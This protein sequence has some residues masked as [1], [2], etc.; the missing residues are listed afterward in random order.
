MDD[1][2]KLLARLPVPA[3]VKPMAPEEFQRMTQQISQEQANDIAIE[4]E[5]RYAAKLAGSSGLN[6]KFLSCNFEN[7]YCNERGQHIALAAAKQFVERFSEHMSTGSGFL[8]MGAPGTGKNHL[9]SA[10]ANALMA[11][12]RSVMVLS[13]MDILGRVRESYSTNESERQLIKAFCKPE[14]LIIDELGLQRGTLDEKLWLHRIINE[15]LYAMRPTGFLT[16]LNMDGL[17]ELL[18]KR[19]YDRMCEGVAMRVK[20]DWQSYRGG[21]HAA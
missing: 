11:K 20:F 2:Q 21:N 7:Y 10:M 16:N 1:L 6:R 8:F 19:T 15:R 14:L 18:E 12:N 17:S 13:V 4:R 3:N 9:A 5:M